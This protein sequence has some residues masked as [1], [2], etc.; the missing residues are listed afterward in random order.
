MSGFARPSQRDEDIHARVASQVN[1]VPLADV[2]EAM[3]RQA[4][5]VNFGVIY[6]QSAAGLAA[7]LGIEQAAAAE[8][9]DG[10][11]RVIRESRASWS[12]SWRNAAERGMLIRSWA[13]GGRSAECATMPAAPGT[14][15]NGPPSTRSSKAPR[16]T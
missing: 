1:G 12:G 4:K 8:F 5:T 13:A 7:R 11:F 10:Y 15:P 6:G 14:S 9:I 3:R 16:P 2:T